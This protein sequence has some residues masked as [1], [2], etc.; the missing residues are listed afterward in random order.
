MTTNSATNVNKR[1]GDSL[2]NRDELVEEWRKYSE[3]LLNNFSGLVDT[4]N[5][6]QDLQDL[7]INIS[8]KRVRKKRIRSS[9]KIY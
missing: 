5:S 6:Q 8:N 1:N 3:E 9:N 2:T 4:S 7:N